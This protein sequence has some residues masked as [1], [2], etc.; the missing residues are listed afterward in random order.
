MEYFGEMESERLL[1]G[2]YIQFNW[3]WFQVLETVQIFQL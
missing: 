3:H 1:N 2:I